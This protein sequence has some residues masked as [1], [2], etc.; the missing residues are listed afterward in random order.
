MAWM[1]FHCA[2]KV[3]DELEEEGEFYD[4]LEKEIKEIFLPWL[5]GDV[6]NRVQSAVVSAAVVDG[7]TD[8]RAPDVPLAV[9]VSLNGT[10]YYL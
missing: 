2:E 6:V 10:S 4:P 3:F 9:F 1:I 8:S 7:K 5:M